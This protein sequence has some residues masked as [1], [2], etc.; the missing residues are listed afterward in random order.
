MYID[1]NKIQIAIYNLYYVYLWGKV[2]E[3]K[4]REMGIRKIQKVGKSTF[5]VSLP[6]EWVKARNLEAKAEVDVQ[7][8][9]DGSLKVLTLDTMKSDQKIKEIMITPKE[10]DAGFIIR[11]IIAAYIANIDLIRIDFSKVNPDPVAKEKIRKMI[12]NKMAGAEI[13]E[14]SVNQISVQI[15]LRPYEFPL[16]KLLLRMATMA[17]DMMTDVVRAINESN[18]S[19]LREV[20]DRDEDVDKLYFMASRWLTSMVSDPSVLHDYGLNDAKDCLEYRLAFRHMERVA[21]HV[22]RIAINYLEAMNDVE[23]SLA[24]ALAQAL[25]GSGNVFIRAVNCL[26]SG[27]LQEANKAIHESRKVIAAGEEIMK[28]VLDQQLCARSIGALII[29]LDSIKRIAEYGIGISEIA[30]NLNTE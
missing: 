23:K 16:D 30:F 27:S 19:I 15:L 13:I 3:G 17:H 9:S 2:R 24:G 20:I 8:L 7:T 26:Q 29:V 11:K 10:P 12:K 1:L 18:A 5:T 25:E 28:N 22:Q 6:R 4:V 14:E 21:D